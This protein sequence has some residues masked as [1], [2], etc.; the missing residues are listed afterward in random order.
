MALM[1]L[2]LEYCVQFWTLRYKKDTG[3]LECFQTR[4]MKLVKVVEN[5]TYEELLREV[6]LFGMEKRKLR[7]DCIT[8]YN[9]LR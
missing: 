3:L 4:A 9:Y 2:L 7:G 6:G 5:K 8:L 1:S